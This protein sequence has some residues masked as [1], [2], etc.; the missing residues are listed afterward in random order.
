MQGRLVLGVHGEHRPTECPTRQ[1]TSCNTA[2][3]CFTVYGEAVLC[4][5]II[6]C[7]ICDL[8]DMPTLYSGVT[9]DAVECISTA[10]VLRQ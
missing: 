7:L 6:A 5:H 3:A 9:M 4:G 8:S 2:R 1:T 10:F